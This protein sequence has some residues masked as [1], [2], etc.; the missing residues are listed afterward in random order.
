MILDEPFSGLD[1]DSAL[2]VQ[3]LFT[4]LSQKGHRIVYSIHGF[5]L[6]SLHNGGVLAINSKNSLKYFNDLSELG[7]EHFEEIYGVKV[8]MGAKG[9]DT[10]Y[11]EIRT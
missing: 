6:L 9:S 10:R 1:I 2:L 3:R 7:E 5:D 8:R 11:L 4:S